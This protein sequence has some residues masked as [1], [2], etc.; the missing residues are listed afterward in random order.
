MD[1]QNW[2]LPRGTIAD[3]LARVENIPDRAVPP[4]SRVPPPLVGNAIAST[5]ANESTPNIEADAHVYA[6]EKIIHGKYTRQGLRYLVKWRGFD[7][8]KNSYVGVDDL[9]EPA[10]LWLLRNPVK[11][12]G[13]PAS[14]E[15]NP[16][17]VAE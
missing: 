5:S 4:D 15:V 3:G 17:R 6:V 7:T 16:S 13:R 14:V 8:T 2:R 9:N 11:M 1:R 10:R 12:I